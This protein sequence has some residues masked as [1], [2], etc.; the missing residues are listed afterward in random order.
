[1]KT[2]SGKVILWILACAL[3]AAV[4]AG[5]KKRI[6]GVFYEGCEET[7]RGF[8]AGIA[9]SGLDAEITILDL[10]LDKSRLPEAVRMARDMKADLVVVHGTTGTL[11]II[12]TIDDRDDP[13]F[14]H[15]IPVVFTVVANP[16][17]S[18]IAQS[19]E[20]SGRPNVAGTFNR[21]PEALN[22][23]IIRKY[24]PDFKKLGLLYNSNEKNSVLTMQALSKAAPKMGVELVALEVAPGNSNSPDPALIP[25]RMRELKDKGVKWLYLGSSS[26]LHVNGKVLLLLRLK[27]A[28]PSSVPM[29]IWCASSA[30]SCPSPRDWVLSVGL[31]RI[32]R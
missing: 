27:T 18:R 20:R 9:D 4:Q 16:F 1:M 2:F 32:R 25:V 28:L 13:R 29:K 10:K 3:C 22:I 5:E 31:L 15:D 11:G 19:F 26:F 23:D 7:C 6:L 14:L 21:V 24:D 17:D 12:G 8:K 30:L